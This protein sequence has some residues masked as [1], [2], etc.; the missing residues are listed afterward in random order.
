M[1]TSV[2]LGEAFRV[3]FNHCCYLADTH[4]VSFEFHSDLDVSQEVFQVTFLKI[5]SPLLQEFFEI[6]KQ[7]NITVLPKRQ[8]QQTQ[9]CMIRVSMAHVDISI[10][11]DAVLRCSVYGISL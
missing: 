11:C 10:D 9:H 7:Y 4:S 2:S 1:T 5:V 3:I 6:L 8:L